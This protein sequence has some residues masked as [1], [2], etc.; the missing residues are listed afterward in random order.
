VSGNFTHLVSEASGWAYA[1][2]FL[3]AFLDALVPV[4]PSETA[5]ITGGVVAAAGDLSLPLVILVAAA[6]AFGGDNAAYFIGR[7][8]G[9]RIAERFFGGE[10]ARR[11]VEWAEGQLQERGGELIVVARFIPGGRTAVTLSAGTLRYAWR[12][13][14]LFDAVAAVSW[15]VYAALVGYVGG[16]TFENAP[17]KGL[18]LALAIAFTV[19]AT[20]ELVRWAL[21]RRRSHG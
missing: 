19:A 17:W 5:V 11:R 18:L 14:A 9:T 16:K 8:F 7:R 10:K 1:L 3:F 13:F 2:I 15:A 20:I 12:R 21:K 6:G 4:V